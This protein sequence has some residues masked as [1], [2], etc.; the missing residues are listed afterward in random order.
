MISLLQVGELVGAGILLVVMVGVGTVAHEF[1]HAAVLHA[2]GVSY[3]IVWFPDS[4][5]PR[6]FGIGVY[7]TWA[8]VTPLSIPETVSDRE[9]RLAAIAPLALA[10]PSVPIILGIIPDP[11]ELGNAFLVVATVAWM[12]CALP[13]PQDFA[14]FWHVDRVMDEVQETP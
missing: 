9:L 6:P 12:G 10:T 11:L 14:L 4:D 3:D 2:L 1:T 8:S 7:R 5:G 13:S